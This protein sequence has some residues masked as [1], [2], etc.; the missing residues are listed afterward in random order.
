MEPVDHPSHGRG[1][2]IAGAINGGSCVDADLLV[3]I[4]RVVPDDARPEVID[5]VCTPIHTDAHGRFTYRYNPPRPVRDLLHGWV[6]CMIVV[7][8]RLPGSD[9]YCK[10]VRW[11]RPSPDDLLTGLGAL[12]GPVSCEL[13]VVP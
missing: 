13:A 1:L 2:V 4:E 5:L 12:L 8:P 6:M 11:Q 9:A 7:Q 10:I 3:A